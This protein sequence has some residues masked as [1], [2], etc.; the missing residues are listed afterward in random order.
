MRERLQTL[1]EFPAVTTRSI[2]YPI[3]L[4]H[5]LGQKADVWNESAVGY[6]KKE[7]GLHF[8]GQLIAPNEKCSLKSSGDVMGDFFTVS[9]GNPA[10]SVNGW[11]SQLERFI[12]IVL[13][14]TKA[15][16]V[17][18]IG[19]SMGGLTARTYLTR[20][21]QDHKT[22]RLITIGS[23]H[24]GSSFAKVWKWKTSV[25][26]LID[27]DAN[28]ITKT[29]VQPLLSIIEAAEQ[30]VPFDSPAVRDLMR[31]QD[32]GKFIAALNYAEHPLDVEYISVVGAVD[33]LRE[34]KSLN[35][36]AAQE[37]FR[38][39]LSVIGLGPEALFEG[40]D[41]VVSASSQTINEIPWFKQN[42]SR[43]RIS[44][45][46]TLGSVHTEHLRNSNEIQRIT[47]EDKPEF[48]GAEFYAGYKGRPVLM[49][50][51]TD[52]LPPELCE[53]SVLFREVSGNKRGITLP[54][55]SARLIQKPDGSTTAAAF[56]EFPADLSFE[57]NITAEF[58][59][60]NS[61]GNIFAS[62]KQ[63]TWKQE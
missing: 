22:Q 17:I 42:A 12:P 7:L 57:Q 55:G 8:G 28:I 53:V 41:G 50:E 20:H 11:V 52:Y 10:D 58:T 48:K 27:G 15:K 1:P 18:I 6:Y 21:L 49:I 61:F 35:S 54:R 51:F 14:K 34:V 5:G 13:E 9:F 4:L 62:L 2:P 32:G 46:V 39:L 33:M 23:P 31:P 37:L 56:I 60:K 16:K 63:W 45:T 24:Q 44:R 36:S 3:I 40:G 38:R 19:Y 25:K 47:L 30:D 29:A 26:S 59:V 43:Q